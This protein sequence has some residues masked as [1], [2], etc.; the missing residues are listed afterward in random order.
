MNIDVEGKI[1]PS[2]VY[3]YRDLSQMTGEEWN[4]EEFVKKYG[5][6]FAQTHLEEIETRK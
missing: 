3:V 2:F 6:T 5:D 1:V 4:Y